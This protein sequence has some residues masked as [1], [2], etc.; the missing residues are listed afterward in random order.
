M[1]PS[2]RDKPN[3]CRREEN[4]DASRKLAAA[5]TSPV[6]EKVIEGAEKIP[7]KNRQ[8][9][10]DAGQQ[11]REAEQQHRKARHQKRE[12]L[13]Q[14]REAGQH[15]RSSQTTSKTVHQEMS[16]LQQPSSV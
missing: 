8:E 13:P 9:Q 3:N 12:A 2:S 11:K 5:D 10:R 15:S 16:W 4:E 1:N 6:A 14:H 7:P